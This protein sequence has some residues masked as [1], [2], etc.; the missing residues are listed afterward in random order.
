M[1]RRLCGALLAEEVEVARDV[2]GHRATFDQQGTTVYANAT[3]NG[4]AVCLRFEG[5]NYNAEPLSCQA[6]DP[7]TH[8]PLAAER[9]PPGLGAGP[10]PSLPR[11]FICILGLYEYH[12][13]FSHVDAAWD[14]YRYRYPF[15]NLVRIVLDRAGCP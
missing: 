11:P 8:R 13:H 2:V 12:C 9:W 7:D 14:R 10:H 4:Q 5:P 1:H 15:Y 6:V 3:C